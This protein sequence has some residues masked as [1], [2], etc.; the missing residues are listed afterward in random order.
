MRPSSKPCYTAILKVCINGNPLSQVG[1]NHQEHAC[2]FPG[3]FIDEF[4]NWKH[5]VKFMNTNSAR[6]LF[7]INQFNYFLPHE[8]LRT[9]YFTLI[10]PYLSYGITVWSSS[11]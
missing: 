1:I 5:H 8:S 9:L 11:E 6:S 3:I 10:H 4:V 7:I 2:T